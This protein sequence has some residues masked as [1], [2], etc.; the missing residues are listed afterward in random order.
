MIKKGK[1]AVP[2]SVTTSMGRY[3]CGSG[4]YDV[5]VV[6][7]KQP[8]LNDATPA[9]IKARAKAEMKKLKECIAKYKQSIAEAEVELKEW[10]TIAGN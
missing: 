7:R 4:L 8:T 10:Q 9:E 3:R 2:P 6:N 1:K 5:E